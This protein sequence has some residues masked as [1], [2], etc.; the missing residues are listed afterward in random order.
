MKIIAS[1]YIVT[2]WI[3]FIELH[4]AATISNATTAKVADI[5]VFG[6]LHSSNHL[7]TSLVKILV[8]SQQLLAAFCMCEQ[9]S[10]N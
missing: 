7:S 9:K 4:I 5:P 1:N 8:H 10:R 3:Y 2:T 6:I